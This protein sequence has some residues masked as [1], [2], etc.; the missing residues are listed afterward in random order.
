MVIDYEGI[1]H[2]LN[3]ECLDLLWVSAA[4]DVDFM[5]A[6]NCNYEVIIDLVYVP[7]SLAIILTMDDRS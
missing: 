1:P 5:L 6:V 7:C 3:I 4:E 2:V